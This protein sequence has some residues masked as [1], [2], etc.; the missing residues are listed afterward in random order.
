MQR[1]SAEVAAHR[2]Q[3]DGAQHA[4]ALR[5][6][7]LRDVL[8]AGEPTLFA[9]LRAGVPWLANIPWPTGA[10]RAPPRGLYLW[11][12]VGRGKT[13]LMDL[14]FASVSDRHDSPR[15][16]D[17]S[18]FYHFM[19]DVHAALADIK[20]HPDPLDL[21]AQRLSERTR[22]ICLDEFFVAD[23]ADAMILAGLF[24]G[25]FRRGVALVATS[26]VPPQ[27][28]Y[29]DGL[30]RQ[31]FLPA[32]ALIQTH[33]EVMHLDGG[34]DYRLRQLER[35]PTYMDSKAIGTAAALQERFAALTGAAADA[36]AIKESSLTIAGRDL[37]AVSWTP[38]TA[39]FEFT[40]LCEG[41]RSQ[42][43]YIELA[44]LFHTIFIS[45]IPTFGPADEDAARRFIMLIDELYDRAVKIV[46]SAA[47]APPA[48]YRGERLKFEF[49]RAASRLIEMQTQRYLAGQH[50]P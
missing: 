34:I 15:T 42:I 39:W 47:A 3:F 50:R 29:K 44:H 2:L 27:D 28:L 26:N 49:E 35:A 46:V 40:E 23:I 25:L 37:R 20:Q 10:S 8:R 45:N 1:W 43:D 18:H 5:L 6:D 36:G 33:V 32:I 31:R 38:G 41:P 19:R 48:L 4:A 12:G 30:Q 21:V 14:F 17:R 22:V 7:V 11:G 24:D 16:A 13:L 9:R